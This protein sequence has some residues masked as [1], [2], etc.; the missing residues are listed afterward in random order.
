MEELLKKE[1]EE[2]K[3]KLERENMKR[4]ASLKYCQQLTLKESLMRGRAYDKNSAKYKAM[5]RKLA[6]FVGSSSVANSIVEN[7]EFKDLLYTMDAHYPVPGRSK[8]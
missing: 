8:N 3:L 6:I 7:M 5:T 2:N 4:A 1:E